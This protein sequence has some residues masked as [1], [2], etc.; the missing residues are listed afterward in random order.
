MYLPH[1]SAVAG[2]LRHGIDHA[3]L[4]TIT[5]SADSGQGER[6]L[7]LAAFGLI[8]SEIGISSPTIPLSP[9]NSR[10]TA[11]TICRLT[12]RQ[13]SNIIRATFWASRLRP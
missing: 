8:V 12:G 4:E 6:D 13:P 2:P 9:A 5:K 7:R 3:V 1:R 11:G 10:P